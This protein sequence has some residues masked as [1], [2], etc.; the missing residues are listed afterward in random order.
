M[1]GTGPGHAYMHAYTQ[2]EGTTRSAFHLCIDDRTSA[3]SASVAITRLGGP[4]HNYIGHDYISHNYIG[5]N[6][7]GHTYIGHTYIGHNYIH[8]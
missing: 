3:K 1:R 4:A 2:M 8:H 7:T 5:H 6:C